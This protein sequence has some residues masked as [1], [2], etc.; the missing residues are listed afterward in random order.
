[1]L[2]HVA[3]IVP[4]VDVIERLLVTFA[5]LDILPVEASRHLHNPEGQWVSLL[6][7]LLGQTIKKE[8][9]NEMEWI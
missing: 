9:C 2:V 4:F 1:M 8:L 7:K 3:I 5:L 6:L